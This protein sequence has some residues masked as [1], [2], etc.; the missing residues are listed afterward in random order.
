MAKKSCQISIKFVQKTEFF[1]NLL[2]ETCLSWCCYRFSQHPKILLTLE[3]NLQTTVQIATKQSQNLP[4]IEH[5]A[6]SKLL[7]DVVAAIIPHHTTTLKNENVFVS[8]HLRKHA[9]SLKA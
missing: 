8:P 4:R 6:Q 3:T 1:L 7:K 9:L 2:Y 5:Y